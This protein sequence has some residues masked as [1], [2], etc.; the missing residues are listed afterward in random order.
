MDEERLKRHD[1]TDEEWER[2]VSLLPDNPRQGGRWADHGTV[3][4]G[5]LP[6]AHQHHLA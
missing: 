5:F 2:L 1:L 4:N 3:I 6:D